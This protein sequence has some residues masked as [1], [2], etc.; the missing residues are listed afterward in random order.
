M[1]ESGELLNHL[2]IS[3]ANEGRGR[4]AHKGRFLVFGGLSKRPVGG[5]GARGGG[6]GGGGGRGG[7]WKIWAWMPPFPEL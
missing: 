2:F 3:K 5:D 6:G 7:L 1:V 4:K